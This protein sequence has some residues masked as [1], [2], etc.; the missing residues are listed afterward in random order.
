MCVHVCVLEEGGHV[1]PWFSVIVLF[2]NDVFFL[3]L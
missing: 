3:L 2:D 1:S